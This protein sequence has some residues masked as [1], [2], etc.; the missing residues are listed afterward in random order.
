MGS[1]ELDAAG[2][3][4]LHDAVAIVTGGASGIGRAT[5]IGL[6]S[7]GCSVAVVDIQADAAEETAAAVRALG[8]RAISIGADLG[9]AEQVSKIVANSVS[10]LGRVDILVN[11]AGIYS[12]TSLLDLSI[13]EWERCHA[14]NLRSFFLLM[15]GAAR[16]MIEQGDGGR[17]VNV[18]SSSAFRA[19]RVSPAYASSKSAILGL[20]R[21]AAGELG[22]FGINV[23]AVAPG[24]TATPTA[25]NSLPRGREDLEAM[26]K[27]DGPASNLLG[28]LSEPEDAAD[29]IIFLCLPESR[30][31]TAQVMHV[32]AGA[33][34]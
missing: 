24:A 33:V 8:V 12:G 18:S 3:R 21:A 6:A 22:P 9:N 29:M 30:Q 25:F 15:Q 2:G 31:I 28:R 4:P 23:N 19:R 10:A 7:K 13:E 34:V 17:I 16:V 27:G 32:S 5:A 11:C 20:T 26:V 1:T 14:V